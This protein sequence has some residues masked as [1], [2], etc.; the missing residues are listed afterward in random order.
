MDTERRREVDLVR[1]IRAGGCASGGEVAEK[2][3]FGGL[4][5]VETGDGGG[6]GDDGGCSRGAFVEECGRAAGQ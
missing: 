2:D 3:A 5:E 1:V 4:D 6:A